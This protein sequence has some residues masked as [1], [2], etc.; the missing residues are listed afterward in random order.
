MSVGDVP[1]EGP[2]AHVS[3]YHGVI[4]CPGD[5]RD[6]G[7]ATYPGDARRTRGHQAG[8]ADTVT[9]SRRAPMTRHTT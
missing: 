5:I 4:S 8:H 7:D 6:T 3:S 9:R 2:M 1:G